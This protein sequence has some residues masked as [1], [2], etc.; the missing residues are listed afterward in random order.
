MSI[1]VHN[2]VSGKN[3]LIRHSRLHTGDYLHQC[4]ICRKPF[5]QKSHLDAH[6]RIHNGVQPFKCTVCDRHFRQKSSMKR[7]LLTHSENKPFSC[8]MCSKKFNQNTALKRHLMT[9]R[10]RQ[11]GADQHPELIVPSGGIHASQDVGELGPGGHGDGGAV[12]TGSLI[13]GQQGGSLTGQAQCSYCRQVFEKEAFLLSHLKDHCSRKPPNPAANV[14]QDPLGEL[15]ADQMA[16][17][18]S[19]RVLVVEETGDQDTIGRKF[20]EEVAKLVGLHAD[21]FSVSSSTEALASSEKYIPMV[22][23]ETATMMEPTSELP[24]ITTAPVVTEDPEAPTMTTAGDQS[25]PFTKLSTQSAVAAGGSDQSIPR[26]GAAV[27][28]GHQPALVAPVPVLCVEQQ[29]TESGGPVRSQDLSESTSAPSLQRGDQ[30]ASTETPSVL[31]GNQSTSAAPSLLNEDQTISVSA[32]SLPSGDQQ[33]ILLP[34]PEDEEQELRVQ[35]FNSETKKVH[36]FETPD[37]VDWECNTVVQS[38]FYASAFRRRRHYVFG[39]SGRPSVRFRAFAGERMEG[40]AWNFTCW[41]IL[42]TFRTD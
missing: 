30:S 2:L 23:T 34:V 32:P 5:P 16:T 28:S 1:I 39:L 9:H 35:V 15:L 29:D 31:T 37:Q 20:E 6:M 41:C 26:M 19:N 8:S 14:P 18:T 11:T 24:G 7:H 27:L 22:V 40:M 3:Q 12:E 21:D 33:I 4:S 13:T 42:T 25:M 10:K 36:V 38:F 17:E